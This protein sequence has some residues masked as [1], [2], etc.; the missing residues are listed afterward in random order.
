MTTAEHLLLSLGIGSAVVLL[1]MLGWL[2]CD[3]FIPS[4]MESY[5]IYRSKKRNPKFWGLEEKDDKT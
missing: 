3:C 1:I 4:I 5:R 2:A